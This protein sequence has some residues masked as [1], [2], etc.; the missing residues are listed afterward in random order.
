MIKGVRK[1]FLTPCGPRLVGRGG[2][3]FEAEVFAEGGEDVWA[4]DGGASEVV[5]AQADVLVAVAAGATGPPPADRPVP[6][7]RALHTGGRAASGNPGE[8]S[9]LNLE[10]NSAITILKPAT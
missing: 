6:S 4:G 3:G 1:N 2:D 7:H 9:A 5:E 10:T 8:I